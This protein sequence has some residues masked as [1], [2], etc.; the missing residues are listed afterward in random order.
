MDIAAR[1][2]EIR[3]QCLVTEPNKSARKPEILS[4]NVITKETSG[5]PGFTNHKVGFG[6]LPRPEDPI[7]SKTDLKTPGSDKKR[8]DLFILLGLV[9]EDPTRSKSKIRWI[10]ET[11][12][13]YKCFNIVLVS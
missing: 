10:S 12:S 7:Q 4:P 9:L 11:S 6:I 3:T 1:P 13:I 5:K 8:T 2:W